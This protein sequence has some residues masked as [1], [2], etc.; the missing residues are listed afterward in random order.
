MNPT[1]APTRRAALLGLASL[2]V[3]PLLAACGGE[4]S[5]ASDGGSTPDGGADVQK[6]I[7][8]VQ[9]PWAKAAESGMTGVFS[10]LLNTT[11]EDVHVTGATSPA[12]GMVELHETVSDPATG[13]ST[14]R[15]AE[16]GFVVPARGEFVLEPGAN[17]IMLMQLT[18]ALKPGDEV[19]V[20]LELEGGATIPFT[21]AV[22][23]FTGA[24]E[25][26]GGASDGGGM[27]G[28]SGMGSDGGH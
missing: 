1:T 10:T 3:L 9:D 15:E 17:H 28:M 21:A 14:M 24:K 25:N 4:S 8:T 13:E 22:K 6:A 12:A 19:E 20:T 5:G 23:E 2:P 7:L 16:G 27:D 18:G 26:Y 11:G